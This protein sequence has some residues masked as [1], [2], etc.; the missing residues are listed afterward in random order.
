M[1]RGLDIV[2]AVVGCSIMVFGITFFAVAPL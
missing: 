2:A 1:A